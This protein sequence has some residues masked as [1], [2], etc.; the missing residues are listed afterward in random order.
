VLKRM[1]M[2]AVAATLALSG[3]GP[4]AAAPPKVVASVKIKQNVIAGGKTPAVVRV[5]APHRVKRLVLQ[6]KAPDGSW[7][8]AA[9]KRGPIGIKNRLVHRP[10]GA[11]PTSYR[12]LVFIK[13][14]KRRM[15][16]AP[17]TT[18]VWAWT[19]L[20]ALPHACEKK[21]QYN[22][23]N[24]GGEIHTD[25]PVLIDGKQYDHGWSTMEYGDED[26]ADWRQT[27]IPRGACRAL[28]GMFGLDDRGDAEGI[29]SVEV[30]ALGGYYD[31]YK[32]GG[33]ERVRVPLDL[34]EKFELVGT[35]YEEY[36]DAPEISHQAYPSIG[37]AEVLCNK[38]F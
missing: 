22:L 8:R 29:G 7:R 38:T 31:E 27:Y 23:D 2:L 1:T 9:V 13:Q 11:G 36:E 10:V 4:A 16:S 3:L 17:V 12:A 30:K 25:K 15:R 35:S 34:V 33:S 14:T 5:T 28:R 18:T 6:R 32:I 26:V 19:P 20:H 37:G 21:D 24:C